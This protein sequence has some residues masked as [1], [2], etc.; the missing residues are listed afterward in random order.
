ME[1]LPLLK[2][3]YRTSNRRYFCELVEL[4]NPTDSRI[5]NFIEQMRQQK[6]NEDSLSSTDQICLEVLL[7]HQLESC[8]DELDA[9]VLMAQLSSSEDPE[10]QHFCEQKVCCSKIYSVFNCRIFR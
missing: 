5:W 8:D 6:M 9:A 4:L 1:N 2:E 7:A 10:I 3:L